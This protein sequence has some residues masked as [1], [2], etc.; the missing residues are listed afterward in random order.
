MTTQTALKDC[1]SC[2]TRIPVPSTRCSSC[3][4]QLGRCTGCKA[5]LVVGI[6]CWDCGGST[7][8]NSQKR[9]STAVSAVRAHAPAASVHFDGSALPLIPL[10]ALRIALFAGFLGALLLAL[11]ATPL[12]PVPRL[13]GEHVTLPKTGA[14]MIQLWAAAGVLLIASGFAGALIRRYRLLKGA[15]Q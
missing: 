3:Q 1:P 11:A 13:I 12:G 9:T 8:T 2:G 4:S 6:E 5:W 14:T 10:L 15:E 7:G